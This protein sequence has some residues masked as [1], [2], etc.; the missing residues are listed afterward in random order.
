M[1]IH[2]NEEIN[3]HHSLVNAADLWEIDSNLINL[4]SNGGV[5]ILSKILKLDTLND[6]QE[7]L[8]KAIYIYSKNTLRYEV[9]DKL[10]YILFSLESL[11]NR[12]EH[13]PITQNISERMAFIVDKTLEGRQ[14]IVKLVKE[15]YNIR[16]RFIH[17]GISELK[18]NEDIEKIKNFMD[19]SQQVFDILIIDAFKIRS[20][21]ELLD[22]IDNMKFS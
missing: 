1:L 2:N 13:E 11:L 7:K 15:I 9:Y 18:N 6:Y 8:L 4:F 5:G 22:K 16:S 17:H 20:K 14:K 19:Y 10:L 12:N 21:D 3:I